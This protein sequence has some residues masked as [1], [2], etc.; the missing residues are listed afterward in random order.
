MYPNCDE[1]WHAW[2]V[3]SE[4]LNEEKGLT[5]CKHLTWRLLSLNMTQCSLECSVS[6][7]RLSQ[8][9]FV[10]GGIRDRLLFICL[11]SVGQ[12]SSGMSAIKDSVSSN[13]HHNVTPPLIPFNCDLILFTGILH[14]LCTDPRLSYKERFSLFVRLNVSPTQRQQV[15]LETR[16]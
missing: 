12:T 4:G 2:L 10:L 13:Q 15:Y 1:Q 8:S 6:V 16:Y 5:L 11:W 9:V 14:H 3:V 7:Q